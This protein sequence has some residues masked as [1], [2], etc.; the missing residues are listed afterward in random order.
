[1]RRCEP[2]AK[3][4]CVAC[5][6]IRV[7]AYI[8][9]NIRA[10]LGILF[11][12][13]KNDKQNALVIAAVALCFMLTL[14]LCYFIDG[15]GFLLA[16]NQSESEV[17][18]YLLCSGTYSDV[19]LAR[20]AAELIRT[21]GG[22]GYVVTGEQ[23]HEVVLAAYASRDDAE[24]VL[25]NGSAGSSAY[26]KEVVVGDIDTGWA[27][28]ETENAVEKAL[29]YYD[30]VFSCLYEA[31]NGL[32]AQTLTLTDVR[33][34]LAV[35]RARVEDLRSEFNAA[36]ASEDDSRYTEIKLALVTAVALLDNV[37]AADSAGSVAAASSLRYQCVQLVF[38]REALRDYING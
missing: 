12:M 6:H 25:Q 24:T 9:N 37:Q 35:C 34:E 19:M 8:T 17:K 26:I 14:G 4:A 7:R 23:N 16:F 1:M 20:S 31:A 27:A 3:I 30:T 13:R 22:A 36:V 38:C 11:C 33:T 5:A 29:G 18:C 32:A 28:K 2:K 15:E 10:R 21:R